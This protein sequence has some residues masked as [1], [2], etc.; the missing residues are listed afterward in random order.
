MIQR[1]LPCIRENGTC[2]GGCQYMYIRSACNISKTNTFK[3]I[4]K[5]L[6]RYVYENM[7]GKCKFSVCQCKFLFECLIS[8][9]YSIIE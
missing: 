1:K 7:S 6:D 8:C 5:D 4:L 2:V 3:A 9:R